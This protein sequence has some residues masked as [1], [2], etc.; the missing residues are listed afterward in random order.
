MR[1]LVGERE[2]IHRAVKNRLKRTAAMIAPNAN[3]ITRTQRLPIG[4][5]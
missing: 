2:P 4:A 3:T 5:L 1:A